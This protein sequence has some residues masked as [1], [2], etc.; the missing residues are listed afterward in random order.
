MIRGAMTGRSTR[1]R[2]FPVAIARLSF[3]LAVSLWFPSAGHAQWTPPIRVLW[4]GFVPTQPPPSHFLALL[5]RFHVLLHGYLALDADAKMTFTEWVMAHG[6]VDPPTVQ[7]MAQ[8]YAWHR[9]GLL[10]P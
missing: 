4:A 3:A 6:I 1:A 5:P 8:L 10:R 7:A 9:S 2:R